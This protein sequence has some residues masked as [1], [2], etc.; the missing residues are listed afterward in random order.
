MDGE[1][2]DTI[3]KGLATGSSRRRL[4]GGLIGGAAAALAGTTTLAAKRKKGKGRKAKVRAQSG[5]EGK[6]Q[7]KRSVCHWDEDAQAYTLVTV[8]SPGADAHIHQHDEDFEFFPGESECC[9]ASDCE[10]RECNDVVCGTEGDNAGKCVYTLADWGESCAADGVADTGVCVRNE[11][12][13]GECIRSSD[14]S[15]ACNSAN[16]CGE[17]EAPFYVP[18]GSEGN[19]GCYSTP[20]GAGLC[21]TRPGGFVYPNSAVS[22]AENQEGLEDRQ[23]CDPESTDPEQCDPGEVCVSLKDDDGICCNRSYP[24]ECPGQNNCGKTG[25]CVNVEAGL[26]ATL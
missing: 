25:F 16:A 14:G 20:Q 8:G 22:C 9:N 21:L 19:C 18:C 4:I 13:T 23:P 5:G 17:D 15:P 2:F 24:E 1:R 11:D 10:P 12:G 7:D 3:A 26:C 6:G